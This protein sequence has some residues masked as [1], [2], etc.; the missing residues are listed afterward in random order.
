MN[1]IHSRNHT[2]SQALAIYLREVAAQPMLT[3]QE[4]EDTTR[5]AA[6]GDVAAQERL[7]R[8]HLPLVVALSRQ[9]S[10]YGLPF[11][12]LISEGNIGLMRAAQ[13][14]DPRF[15]TKFSTYAAV[16]IKQRIHRAITAQG[17]AV[18][19]PVWRSQRLRK[20]ARLNDEL[21]STLGRAPTESE[22]ASRLGL[23][24]EEFAEIEG[25]R[26]QVSSL[27]A[28][29]SADEDT[30]TSHLDRMAD[31]TAPDPAGM[32]TNQ[33]LHD[34]L[35][36]ALHDLDDRELDVVSSKFGLGNRAA[37]SFREIGRSLG[38]SHEWIRRIAELALVKVRRGMQ[39]VASLSMVE[40]LRRRMAV[41]ERLEKLGATWQ[42]HPVS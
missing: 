15:G 16:W 39:A 29:L 22:L 30:E 35:V 40:Q 26:V 36:A 25:D 33:E 37:R 12:D 19:I 24:A 34:E 4:L 32:L 5:L 1:R 28:T 8:A 23:S 27:D 3:P 20:V 42:P 2:D 41:R 18:R 21:A 14:F 38:K 17:R 9:Y 13:L 10:G 11:S 31:E 7:V 6:Q